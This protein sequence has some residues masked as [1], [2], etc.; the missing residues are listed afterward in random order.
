[1]ENDKLLDEFYQIYLMHKDAMAKVRKL[2]I[3]HGGE[4]P[5]IQSIKSGDS[6]PYSKGIKEKIKFI[7]KKFPTQKMTST[8]IGNNL[9]TYEPEMNQT[10]VNQF[11]SFLGKSNEIGVEQE[12]NKN[13]YYYLGTEMKKQ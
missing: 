1:M 2:I 4:D 3:D 8:D 12:G 9:Q 7:L 11:C 5:E 6:Y 13:K 10:S